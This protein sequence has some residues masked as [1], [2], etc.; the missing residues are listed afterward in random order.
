[1]KKCVDSSLN[2][3]SILT[4]KSEK[5]CSTLTCRCRFQT[6]S[7]NCGQQWT[8]LEILISIAGHNLISTKDDILLTYYRIEWIHHLSCNYIYSTANSVHTLLLT[9]NQGLFQDFSGPPWKI[10]KDLFGARECLN[11]KK[12]KWQKGV[13]IHQHSTLYLSKQ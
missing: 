9:T 13:K 5:W 7:T 11:I 4:N 8:T 3:F 10:F 12:K 2:V 1:M 6:V